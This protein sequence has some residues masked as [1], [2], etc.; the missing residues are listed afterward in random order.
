MKIVLLNA[1]KTRVSFVAD[2][3]QF[4]TSRINRYTQ[5]DIIETADTKHMSDIKAMQR[6]EAEKLLKQIQPTDFVILLDEK[7]TQHGSIAFAGALQKLIESGNRRIVF[8][9]AGAYGAHEVL[10]ARTNE[11]WSLSK[12]TFPHQLVRLI[13]TEQIYRAFSIM[14]NEPYHHEG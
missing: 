6:D 9:I 11:K 5:W 3:I 12:L 14:R 10:L 4:Y 2:G 1:G 13:L 7:G 8:V